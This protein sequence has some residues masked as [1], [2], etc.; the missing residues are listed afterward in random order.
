MRLD[1]NHARLAGLVRRWNACIDWCV[2]AVRVA[3]TRKKRYRRVYEC[4]DRRWSQLGLNIDGPDDS[5][6]S[7]H[8]MPCPHWSERFANRNSILSTLRIADRFF[9]VPPFEQ[10]MFVVLW[11]LLVAHGSIHSATEHCSRPVCERLTNTS[12]EA[13]QRSQRSVSLRIEEG[14]AGNA[15]R[16]PS[17][18][19]LY[20]T[21]KDLTIVR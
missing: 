19:L 10:T 6:R 20:K 13:A 1:A 2:N 4:G 8:V 9:D 18:N 5:T 11:K 7:R 21:R 15:F 12:V 16:R 14:F 17:R 3:R